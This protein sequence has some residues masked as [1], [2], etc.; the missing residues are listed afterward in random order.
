MKYRTIRVNLPD[1]EFAALTELAFKEHRSTPR[2]FRYMALE[3][4]KESK[5]LEEARERAHMERVE[6]FQPKLKLLKW[7]AGGE[8]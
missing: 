3:Y 5:S 4:L 8:A 6:R 2:Q 1:E 7:A